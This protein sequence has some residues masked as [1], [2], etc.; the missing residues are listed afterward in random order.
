M[1]LSNAEMLLDD[2]AAARA[3]E[4]HDLPCPPQLS[5]EEIK[6]RFLTPMHVLRVG[7]DDEGRQFVVFKDRSSIIKYDGKWRNGGQT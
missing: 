3:L 1:S 7:E 2:V 6:R 4:R 5:M